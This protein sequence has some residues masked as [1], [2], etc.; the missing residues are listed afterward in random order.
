VQT[1]TEL[2]RPFTIRLLQKGPFEPESLK[3]H[4][5]AAEFPVPNGPFKGPVGVLQ[6]GRG[7]SGQSKDVG[8]Q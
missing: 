5:P 8:T 1:E 2:G 7:T 4:V 3:L 6:V